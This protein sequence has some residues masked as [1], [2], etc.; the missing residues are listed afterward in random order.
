MY[1]CTYICTT[2]IHANALFKAIVHAME[3]SRQDDS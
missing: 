2:G 3:I 1:S